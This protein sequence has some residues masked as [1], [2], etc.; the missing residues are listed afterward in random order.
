MGTEQLTAVPEQPAYV[1][2]VTPSLCRIATLYPVIAEPPFGGAI[3]AIATSV[4]P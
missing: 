4:V 3:Q 2:Y 1:E